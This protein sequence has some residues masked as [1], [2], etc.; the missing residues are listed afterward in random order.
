ME[1]QFEDLSAEEV[2]VG[3]DGGDGIREPNLLRDDLKTR[4][5]GPGT[6][7]KCVRVAHD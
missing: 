5:V 3:S 6:S 4:S 7:E 1:I 2:S